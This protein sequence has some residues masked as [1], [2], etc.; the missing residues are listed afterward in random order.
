MNGIVFISGSRSIGELSQAAQQSLDKIMARNLRVVI[1][2]CYGVDRLVQLYLAEHGYADSV[3]VYT[4]H[5]E[6][7]NFVD[8]AFHHCYVAA[9]HE[10]AKNS[11]MAFVANFGLAIWDGHSHGTA[12]AINKMKAKGIPVKVI[13]QVTEATTRFCRCGTYPREQDWTPK[14]VTEGAARCTKC[15]QPQTPEQLRE[16]D[17]NTPCPPYCV[18]CAVTN[19]VT[20]F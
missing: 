18:L 8:S 15:L 12:D 7:R 2:D 13:S 14:P 6:P 10:P 16:W 4:I 11:A 9:T 3:T 5:R 17:G 19:R 20:R 1:G